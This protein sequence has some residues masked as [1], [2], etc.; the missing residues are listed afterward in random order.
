[1]K[2]ALLRSECDLF[3]TRD[4]RWRLVPLVLKQAL[5]GIR[6]LFLLRAREWTY[7]I[8]ISG[9]RCMEWL[10]SLQCYT[11]IR[12]QPRYHHRPHA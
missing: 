6:L 11:V 1:M 7:L 9:T 4:G 12:L 5:A 10:A 2:A 8:L 3:A